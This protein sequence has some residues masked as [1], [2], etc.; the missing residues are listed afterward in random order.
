MLTKFESLE[1]LYV[2]L[3]ALDQVE[4]EQKIHAKN[5]NVYFYISGNLVDIIALTDNEHVIKYA[6]PADLSENAQIRFGIKSPNKVNQKVYG[7]I[8][9]TIGD[10]VRFATID[11][12]I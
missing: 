4:D 2:L 9:G 11:G 5:T 1:Y 3:G 6:L 12:N 8:Q 10:L 7:K